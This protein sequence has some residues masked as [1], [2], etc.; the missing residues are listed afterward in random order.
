[1]TTFKTP[2]RL[3]IAMLTVILLFNVVCYFYF[4]SALIMLVSIVVTILGLGIF[5]SISP[6]FKYGR[7]H[8]RKLQRTMVEAKNS[9]L[10]LRTIIDA[11]PDSIFIK[12]DQHRFKMVNKAYADFVK[13]NMEDIIGKTDIETGTPEDMVKGNPEKGIRGFWQDDNEVLTTGRPKLIPEEPIEANGEMRIL[14][15]LKLPLR[16]KDGNVWGILG[17]V[18]DITHFKQHEETLLKKDEL[19]QAVSHATY[20]LISNNDLEAAMGQ[21]VK[22]LGLQMQVHTVNLYRTW[23]NEEEQRMYTSQIVRW[24]A[25]T[26]S[27]EYYNA[28]LQNIVFDYMPHIHRQLL[29]NKIYWSSTRELEDAKLKAWMEERDICSMAVLPIFSNGQFWGFVSFHNYANEREWTTTECAILQSFSA[30]LGA[31]IERTKLEEQMKQAK[32]AAED[33]SRSK[34]EFMANMSH[35]LRTP[36]NGIIGFT[37]LVLTTELQPAQAEYLR[38]V[39]KSAYNLLNIINDILDFSKIEAGKLLIDHTSFKLNELIEETV[40]ILSIKALEKNLELICDID[41]L[42]P[43]L[44]QGDPVR[45]QQ[46]LVNLLG[47]AIKF[48][49]TGDICLTARR[50]G[51]PYMKDDKQWLN[52][53]IEVKDSGIGIPREKLEKIFESFTQADA[54]TTRK[55]GGTGLGLTISK[56]LLELMGGVMKVES[57]PGKGSSFILNLPLELMEETPAFALA[58]KPVL[59]E[60]LVIDDNHTNC[61]LMQGIFQFLDIPC[62]ICYSGPEAL[63]VICQAMDRDTMFDLIITDHQMPG[64]DGISLVKE[65]KRI[66]PEDQEPF[67][68]MLSSLE[69]TLYQQEAIKA[70]INKFLSKPVKL[71]ELQNILSAIFDRAYV[72]PAIHAPQLP[73]AGQ[74]LTVLVAEDDVMNM[75]L[76]TTVLEKMGC[77]VVPVSNGREAVDIFRSQR[78]DLIFMDIN[79]PEMDGYTATRH[80]RQLPPP[81]NSVSIIALTADAMQEDRE[82]AL[83]AGMNDYISKPF[84]LKEIAALLNNFGK[85]PYEW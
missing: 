52:I 4:A 38:N 82:K 67:I 43:A 66:L 29:Q 20:E 35:E 24:N 72:A 11:T 61:K 63:D 59:R 83:A 5:V 64:M 77:K 23:M 32:L 39:N 17:F 27:I 79:M 51:S 7:Q 12:D 46:V 2:N 44:F 9:E 15:T 50:S 62:T 80:I 31:S 68:L 58:N 71:H 48:T 81:L 76:I 70:G 18:Q 21:A 85:Q 3:I 69:K 47:N 74:G 49:E 22:L 19:M 55:F 42:L 60:V 73:A 75:A 41:P 34:S 10:L 14:K 54:S 45:I 16:G 78:V 57:E 36:M 28:E 6:G 26:E 84:Q 56:N 30:T 65:M 40:E 25:F 37:D 53:E 33:A 8:Y 13:L 1:M